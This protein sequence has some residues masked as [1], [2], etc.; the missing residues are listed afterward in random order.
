MKP[1]PHFTLNPIKLTF[2]DVK[3]N[4]LFYVY[5]ISTH[6]CIYIYIFFLVHNIV[7]EKSVDHVAIRQLIVKYVELAT[8]VGSTFLNE[9]RSLAE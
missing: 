2:S 6:K 9:F 1:S 7:V 8:P 3:V 4:K 5:Y